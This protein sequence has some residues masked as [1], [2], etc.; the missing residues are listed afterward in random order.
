MY[1]ISMHSGR[2]N[3]MK[4]PIKPNLSTKHVFESA[5]YVMLHERV[6]EQDIC[7]QLLMFNYEAESLFR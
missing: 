3:I 6:L 5:L 1:E 2:V 7:S 4:Y